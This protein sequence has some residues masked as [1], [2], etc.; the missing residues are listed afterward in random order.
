MTFHPGVNR[1]AKVIPSAFCPP[2]KKTPRRRISFRCI[3]TPEAYVTSR[4][5]FLRPDPQF[6]DLT[7]K[8]SL[9][10]SKTIWGCASFF[11][12]KIVLRPCASSDPSGV[13]GFSELRHILDW[14]RHS[15]GN[16]STSTTM[17]RCAPRPSCPH[18][19]RQGRNSPSSLPIG[20][21]SRLQLI[22][23]IERKLQKLDFIKFST[24]DGFIPFCLQCGATSLEGRCGN[25]RNQR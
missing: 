15:T 6:P 16:L 8:A 7:H 20:C 2:P 5:P 9:N 19:T 1:R 18:R 24:A 3:L 21:R 11:L 13:L 12:V 23:F 10:K 25:A 4:H 14:T 17:W 22:D